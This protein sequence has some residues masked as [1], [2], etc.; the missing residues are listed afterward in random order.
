MKAAPSYTRVGISLGSKDRNLTH[1]G[2]SLDIAPAR[3]SAAT[4]T[5]TPTVSFF[6]PRTNT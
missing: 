2:W 5:V 4:H 1:T 6:L 3:Y